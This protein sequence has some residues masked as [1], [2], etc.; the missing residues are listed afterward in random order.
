MNAKEVPTTIRGLHNFMWSKSR[1][2]LVKKWLDNDTITSRSKSDVD[3]AIAILEHDS[4]DERAE[5]PAL[6]ALAAIAIAISAALPTV[7]STTIPGENFRDFLIGAMQFALIV[8]T[9]LM[10][11]GVVCSQVAS[12]RRAKQIGRLYHLRHRES[13]QARHVTTLGL[14]RIRIRTK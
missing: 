4:N 5:M 1:T 14:A 9:L 2:A 11:V 3:Y 6:L 12:H 7:L 13:A 8:V 10:A